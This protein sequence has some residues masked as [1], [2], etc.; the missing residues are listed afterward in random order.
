VQTL[1]SF[2]WLWGSPSFLTSGNRKKLFFGKNASS[3]QEWG[4]EYVE[5]NLYSSFHGG[6]ENLSRKLE[7]LAENDVAF[8]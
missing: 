1:F 4:R 6:G 5:K 8:K 3:I 7:N 2:S